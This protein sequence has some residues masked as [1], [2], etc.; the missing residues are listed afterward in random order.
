MPGEGAMIPDGNVGRGPGD[1]DGER[2]GDDGKTGGDSG[3]P[4]RFLCDHMLGSLARWLRFL[5]YDTM[6]PEAMDDTKLLKLARA[7]G[8][9]LLTRDIELSERAGKDG[10]LVKSIELEGQLR[11][12][13]REL[14]LDLDDARLLTRCSLCNT[15]LEDVPKARVKGMVPEAV[16]E[17]QEEFWRCPGCGQLYWPGSHYD[18]IREK[19]GA[20]DKGD[21]GKLARH[22]NLKGN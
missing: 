14:H 21:C 2:Q 18:K 20:L 12:V 19:L 5:G 9:F 15:P 1:D 4:P 11:V 17:R 22:S 6:Y 3:K 7:E 16:F 8:R 13:K 10:M